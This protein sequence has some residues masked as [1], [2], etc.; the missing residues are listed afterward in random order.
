MILDRQHV[1]VTTNGKQS[2]K[3]DENERFMSRYKEILN[4]N[5]KTSV[6]YLLQQAKIEFT[7]DCQQKCLQKLSKQKQHLCWAHTSDNFTAGHVG[8]QRM[9]SAIGSLKGKGK[10]SDL[11]KKCSIAE[12]HEIFLNHS[13]N[14]NAGKLEKIKLL[15]LKCKRQFS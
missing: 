9:E 7:D 15:R 14:H 3:K 2:G 8:D 6:D 10:L 13:Q 5:C 12:S 11:L 4:C 1:L